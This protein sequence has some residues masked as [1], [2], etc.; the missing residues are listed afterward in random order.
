MLRHS[1][2]AA[3]VAAERRAAQELTFTPQ[4]SKHRKADVGA[5]PEAR[6]QRT[7]QRL[8]KPR[9][10]HWQKC[11]HQPPPSAKRAS[12]FS[13]VVIF[14]NIYGQS[15]DQD[16]TATDA[17][18]RGCTAYLLHDRKCILCVQHT[19]PLIHPNGIDYC[20]W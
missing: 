5:A 9:T 3:L 20:V 16:N 6:V 14:L 13:P 12:A 4:L 2:A 7:V 11:T 15:V 1:R 8:S 18:R 17:L 10:A 19:D